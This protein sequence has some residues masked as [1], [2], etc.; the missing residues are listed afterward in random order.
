MVY[1]I[2][3]PWWLKKLY[4]EC[5]WD[6][7]TEEKNLYL[8]FDDGP[9]PVA[10]PYV[11]EQLKRFDAKAT[12][13]CIGK[14]VKEH[15]DLYQKIIN[16]GH[17]P[18]NHTYDHLNGWKE[19]DKTYLQNIFEA[20]KIIDSNLFR[21][22]YGRVTKFQLKQL[23][24]DKYKLTTIMWSIISGDFDKTISEDNC[25]L[26][27]IKNAKP[28]SIILFHESEKAY[29][30]LLFALPKVLEYF[31]KRGYKFKAIEV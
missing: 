21:P 14:N 6:I 2:K 25:L 26:N 20:K 7:K 24:A 18:G 19:A 23:S 12:F 17:K 9:H 3:T 15:F 29:S 1:L 22:P 8:T 16:E 31:S 10:T 28:G 30:K 11:L 5:I 4:S 27:V 13:F